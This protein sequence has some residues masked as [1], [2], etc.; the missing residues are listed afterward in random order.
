MALA[1]RSVLLPPCVSAVAAAALVWGPA[2][3]GLAAAVAA[4]FV[5]TWWL[6]RH[7]EPPPIQAR[8]PVI[9]AVAGPGRDGL[10][11]VGAGRSAQRNP[12]GPAPGPRTRP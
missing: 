1:D 4:A 2:G 5:W 6:E 3:V 10:Q 7:P 9:V 11:V 8:N 12:E